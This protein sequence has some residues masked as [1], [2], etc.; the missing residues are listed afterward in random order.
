MRKVYHHVHFTD[1]ENKAQTSLINSQDIPVSERCCCHLNSG[2]RTTRPCSW[3]FGSLWLLKSGGE[4]TGD[5]F[6][7]LDLQNK[8]PASQQNA[9]VFANPNAR[10]QARPTKARPRATGRSILTPLQML[11]LTS[12]VGSRDETPATVPSS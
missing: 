2:S 6:I 4:N 9:S 3:R 7:L 8:C 10:T 11:K 5:Y 12:S 1:E